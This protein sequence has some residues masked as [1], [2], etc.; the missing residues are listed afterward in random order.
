[1]NKTSIR[2]VFTAAIVAGSIFST[3]AVFGETKN[4]LLFAE[5]GNVVV[6]GAGGATIPAWGYSDVA[7]QA[8]F[9]GPQL[10]VTEGDTVNITL[11]NYHNRNHNLVVQ[12]LSDS[13]QTAVQPS[14]AYTYSFTADRAGTFLYKDTLNSNINRSMGMYGAFIVRPADGTK[15]VYHQYYDKENV[16]VVGEMDKSRWNDRAA[17][18]QSVNTSVYKPNYFLM[19]GQGGF[20]AMHDDAGTTMTGVVGQ[21]ALARIVNGGQFSHSLHFHGGHILIVGENGVPLENPRWATTV[22]VKPNSTKDVIYEMVQPGVF[23]MHIH[24][25][26]METAN[27]VYLNGVAA[28]IVIN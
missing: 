11:I 27:G 21:M 25:A 4:F 6:S 3:G 16:W 19:N 10:E 15:T 24:T 12:G 22:S 17:S 2:V 7:G 18:G 5:T 23:P 14:Q 26:Q 28:M 13:N 9:P 20:S 8:K 1:M